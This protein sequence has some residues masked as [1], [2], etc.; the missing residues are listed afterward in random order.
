MDS[1]QYQILEISDSESVI[2]TTGL[3]DQ[4]TDYRYPVDNGDLVLDLTADEYRF[5]NDIQDDKDD[6][7]DK[8]VIQI[9]NNKDKANI[10]GS[11]IDNSISLD[12]DTYA[13][14][15]EA[16]L[17]DPEELTMLGINIDEIRA[18]KSLVERLEMENKVDYELAIRL[19]RDMEMQDL[20]SQPNG[21]ATASSSTSTSSSC[22]SGTPIHPI[23]NQHFITP[24]D[25]KN[26]TSSIHPS[27][28]KREI[29]TVNNEQSRYLKRAKM[30]STAYAYKG[31][32]PIEIPDDIDK[33]KKPIELIDDVE[34]ID[35]T[36]DNDGSLSAYYSTRQEYEYNNNIIGGEDEDETLSLYD[37][38]SQA[39][40][41]LQQSSQEPVNR[42][43]P[44]QC[45]GN[46][47]GSGW[48]KPDF[49]LNYGIPPV[50]T[51]PIYQQAMER[52]RQLTNNISPMNY[53]SQANQTNRSQAYAI[54]QQSHMDDI[55]NLE[56]RRTLPRL[57]TRPTPVL[58]QA[59]TEKELRDLLEHVVY[60]D[61]PPPQDRTGTPDGLSITLLEHQKIGLQWMCKM[62]SSNNKG[63]ILAD[64]MGLGKVT[65]S[66]SNAFTFNLFF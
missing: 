48:H 31:K 42:P 16:G 25:I 26:Q 46:S 44:S 23:F 45:T 38:L 12:D 35:L 52:M 62:E 8:E 37:Y 39:P 22:S 47:G 63:G 57:Q 20:L 64:D 58:S 21:P 18:Q 30:E 33:G 14:F 6:K 17:E 28:I 27:S 4:Q 41:N 59:E 49:R 61:P 24:Q 66:C 3:N 54:L 36:D 7:D 2:D 51:N 34:C 40:W 29:N 56:L 15:I 65:I 5:I 13:F 11:S 10:P 32:S 55:A 9:D 19:Q 43:V 53:T 60:D 50:N 1:P